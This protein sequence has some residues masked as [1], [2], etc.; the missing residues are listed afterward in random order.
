M[1][2]WTCAMEI[3]D[4][5]RA[6]IAGHDE[7]ASTGE[8]YAGFLPISTVREVTA[9]R[10]PHVA[11]RPHQVEDGKERSV[12]KMAVYV[13]VSPNDAPRDGAAE[14]YHILEFL[15]FSLLSNNPIKNRWKIEDGSLETSIP[16]EQPYPKLWGRMDF[17]VILPQAENV[18]NDILGGYDKGGRR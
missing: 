15:R 3:A 8:V 5:L 11:I 4:F 6:Q 12:A 16:D 7:R 2:P 10:C 18:R 14:L 17:D 1:T 13:V 9:E